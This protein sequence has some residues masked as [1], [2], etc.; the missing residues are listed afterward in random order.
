MK[1]KVQGVL[2]VI[3]SLGLSLGLLTNC[4]K[5]DDDSETEDD[6]TTATSTGSSTTATV[7]NPGTIMLSLDT[8]MGTAIQTS[9]ASL[10]LGVD[11]FTAST[12]CKDSGTPTVDESNADYNEYFWKCQF[13]RV[14]DGPDT[15]RGGIVRPKQVLCG[16]GKALTAGTFKADGTEYSFKMSIDPD[17]WGQQ[18]VD[19]VKAEMPQYVNASTGYVELDSKVTGYTKGSIPTTFTSNTEWDN[20][21]KVAWGFSA[22]NTTTYTVLVKNDSTTTAA[23]I[24]DQST[25]K[26]DVVFAVSVTKG[27][28]GK[29]TLRYEGRF[30]NTG[31]GEMS[32]NTNYGSRHVTA[33]V[34][35]SYSDT[36]GFS[37]YDKAYGT[38][39]EIGNSASGTNSGTITSYGYK[40]R[41]FYSVENFNT[42]AW[43]G[44]G[45]TITSVGTPSVDQ[46][47]G[48][49]S[50][51][52]D[53]LKFTA[54]TSQMPGFLHDKSSTDYTG[55][56]SW[57]KSQG[58][59]AFTS[60]VIG[61]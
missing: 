11:N 1:I 9:A 24:L 6:T 25:G 44:S 14:P 43:N 21:F 48:S 47:A 55:S 7:N 49:L 10:R 46:P 42:I 31:D 45:A 23:S 56:A 26:I 39:L 37:S 12:D 41:S 4:S 61:N 18:F 50:G 32:S 16:V 60:V 3:A 52:P 40:V 8:A 35:G 30:P 38:S 58:P 33:M 59:L 19:M 29:A 22:D 20:A 53:G 57:H 28:T 36:A 5:K 15:V 51:A 34:E 54:S 27:A 13:L 17:C 2:P